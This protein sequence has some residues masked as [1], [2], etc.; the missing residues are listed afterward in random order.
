[1]SHRLSKIM[2]MVRCIGTPLFLLTPYAPRIES[3]EPEEWRLDDM[4]PAACHFKSDVLQL[5]GF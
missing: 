3:R 1:M 4:N 5:L 2:K